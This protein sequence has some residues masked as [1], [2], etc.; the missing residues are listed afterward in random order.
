MQ[1]ISKEGEKAR[2]GSGTLHLVAGWISGDCC[3]NG[4]HCFHGS[5]GR[6]VEEGWTVL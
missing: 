1:G 5:R 4:E 2:I 3:C 6:V